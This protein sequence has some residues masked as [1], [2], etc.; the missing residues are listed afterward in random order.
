MSTSKIGRRFG[1]PNEA[2]PKAGISGRKKWEKYHKLDKEAG[3]KNQGTL[4][5]WLIEK[6][7]GMAV[8]THISNLSILKLKLVNVMRQM[9]PWSSGLRRWKHQNHYGNTNSWCEF[10]KDHIHKIEDYI[11]LK[12]VVNKLLK[13]GSFGNSFLTGITFA[14]PPWHDKV[15]N[16]ISD[17]SKVSSITHVASKKSTRSA[18]NGRDNRESR[19]KKKNQNK[20][21]Q[22]QIRNKHS[23]KQHIAKSSCSIE[24]CHGRE[25][26]GISLGLHN[27][28]IVAD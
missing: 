18:K 8:S 24:Y 11:L 20:K 16:V 1:I 4:H 12:M 25:V 17:G 3:G 28:L 23:T 15:I 5:H 26:S 22:Q 2:L 13:K 27:Q 19:T 14:L 9:F 7:E 21:L 10:H 6:A